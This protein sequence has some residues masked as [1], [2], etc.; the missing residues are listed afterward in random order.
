MRE[1]L[2]HNNQQSNSLGNTP[3]EVSTLGSDKDALSTTQEEL[4]PLARAGSNK[5]YNFESILLSQRHS[6]LVTKLERNLASTQAVIAKQHNLEDF[7]N[8]VGAKLLS[9]EANITIL[10]QSFSETN[11]TTIALLKQLLDK[12]TQ[13]HSYDKPKGSKSKEDSEDKDTP[14]YERKGTKR[15]ATSSGSVDVSSPQKDGEFV[16]MAE[17]L[18]SKR[19]TFSAAPLHSKATSSNKIEDTSLSVRPS[20]KEVKVAA[21]DTSVLSDITACTEPQEEQASCD[22]LIFGGM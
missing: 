17:Y 18:K 9:I 4:T 22:D 10:S 2:I 13:D 20:S 1:S 19:S 14:K 15:K 7:I 21:C 11:K 16:D 12:S 5:A 8:D 3:N 6:E